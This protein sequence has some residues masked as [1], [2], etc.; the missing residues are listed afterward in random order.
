MPV[1]T[2]HEVRITKD[3]Q[4]VIHNMEQECERIMFEKGTNAA[5]RSYRTMAVCLSRV[6]TFS[7]LRGII[8][9]C[10]FGTALEDCLD[11]IIMTDHITLGMNY[12]RHSNEWSLNS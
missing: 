6:M 7:G 8:A 10:G 9:D 11:L 12:S 4:Q 5:D 2:D 1:F 3:A